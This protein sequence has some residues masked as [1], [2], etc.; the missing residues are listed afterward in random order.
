[1]NYLDKIIKNEKLR[2]FRIYDIELKIIFDGLIAIRVKPEGEI[3]LKHQK[4]FLE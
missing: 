4:Q 1:M 3:Q 2:A